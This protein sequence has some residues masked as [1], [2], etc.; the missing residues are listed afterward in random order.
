MAIKDNVG[1]WMFEEN[2]IK[3]FIRAGFGELYTTSLVSALRGSP[4]SSQW[5]PRLTEEEKIN[6]SGEVTVEEIKQAL[7]SLKAFKALGPDGLHGGFTKDFD[8]LWEVL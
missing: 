5:H 4:L 1:E 6:I 3:G 8:L 7:W 2:D